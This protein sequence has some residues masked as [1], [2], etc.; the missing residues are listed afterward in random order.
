MIL[1]GDFELWLCRII[2]NIL[3]LEWGKE[4]ETNSRQKKVQSD[5]ADFPE[6][7]LARQLDFT[8]AFGGISAVAVV[9]PENP[10][11]KQGMD[12]ASWSPAA[13]SVNQQQQPQINQQVAATISVAAG[14]SHPLTTAS[15]SIVL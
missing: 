12:V 15:S 10:Q 2:G 7:K 13:A 3:E 6:K 14:Q 4:K 8:A 11:S 9:F 1:F 5:S